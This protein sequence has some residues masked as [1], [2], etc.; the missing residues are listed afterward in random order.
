MR[1]LIL[2]L[3]QMNEARAVG[4]CSCKSDTPTEIELV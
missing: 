1:P 2:R 4:A 3:V